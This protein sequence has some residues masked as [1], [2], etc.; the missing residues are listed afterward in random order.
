MRLSHARR[1]VGK[2]FVLFGSSGRIRTYNPSV[3]SRMLL[4]SK[5]RCRPPIQHILPEIPRSLPSREPGMQHS[6][7]AGHRQEIPESLPA[8][9]PLAEGLSAL[10]ARTGPLENDHTRPQHS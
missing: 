8:L 1:A 10:A 6:A 5:D 7:I 4:F 3:N 9:A 2:Y